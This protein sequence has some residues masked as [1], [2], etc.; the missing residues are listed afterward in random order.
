MYVSLKVQ[1][2]EGELPLVCR[3]VETGS[4][5]KAATQFLSDWSLFMLNK[6]THTHTHPFL[7]KRSTFKSGP[8]TETHLRLSFQGY[9]Y[10]LG[11]TGFMEPLGHCFPAAERSQAAQRKSQLF[12]I[13]YSSNLKTL[14]VNH[15]ITDARPFLSLK[16]LGKK[17]YSI[18]QWCEKIL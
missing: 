6:Q 17:W 13:S 15:E 18:Q 8:P 9:F 12:T 10:W 16:R 4:R 5:F 11:M 1:W 14:T 3:S 7:H 2:C